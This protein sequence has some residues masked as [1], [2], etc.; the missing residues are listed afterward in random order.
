MVSMAEN[1]KMNGKELEQVSGGGIS[2]LSVD[3]LRISRDGLPPHCT[4]TSQHKCKKCGEEF[5]VYH[6]DMEKEMPDK[7]KFCSNCRGKDV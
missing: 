3:I 1:E 6:W 5:T 2:D 4:G 7:T